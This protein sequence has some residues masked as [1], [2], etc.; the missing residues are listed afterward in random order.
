MRKLP[1]LARIC[2]TSQIEGAYSF[3]IAAPI[4]DKMRIDM[5]ELAND[6]NVAR[7][8]DLTTRYRTA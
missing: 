1:L 6:K 5:T 7:A 4:G 8:A 2:K 3:L